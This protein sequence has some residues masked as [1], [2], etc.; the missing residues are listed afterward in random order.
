MLIE[1]GALVPDGGGM[2][3]VAEPAALEVP[4]TIEALVAARLAQLPFGDRVALE[5]GSVVGTQFGARE[6]ARSAVT[7][8]IPQQSAR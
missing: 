8:V 2:R 6:I 7:R 3:L 1:S 5:R 4:P